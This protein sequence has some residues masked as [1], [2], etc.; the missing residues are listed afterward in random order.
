MWAK[1]ESGTITEMI[2]KP[3]AITIGDVQYP[4]NIFELWT[5]AELKAINIYPVEID[6]SERKDAKYYSNTEITYTVM[7]TK[8]KGA[9]G[10]ATA[11]DLATLK[12]QKKNLIDEEAFSILKESDWLVVRAAEGGTAV[13]SDW[14]TYRAAVRTKA[15]DMQTLIDGAADVDALAALYVYN[16]DDPPTRPL[17]EWPNEP[18]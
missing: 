7:E 2:P 18:S 4:R 9:Y 17:G 1:V 3:K 16:T 5:N 8:V 13:P 10:T 15:N 12:A 6:S 11:K 14:T